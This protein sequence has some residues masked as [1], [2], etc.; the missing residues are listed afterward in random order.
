MR[1]CA[2]VA[3]SVVELWRALHLAP[4]AEESVRALAARSGL[5]AHAVDASIDRI[6][7]ATVPNPEEI[8][9]KIPRKL[10]RLVLA[11]AARLRR[12]ADLRTAMLAAVREMQLDFASQVLACLEAEK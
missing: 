3:L 9:R 6:L 10:L 8:K 2:D 7:D 5:A 11:S 12:Y 1:T 4:V